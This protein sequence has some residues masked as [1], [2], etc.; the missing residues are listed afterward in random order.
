MNYLM[1][2]YY[3][4]TGYAGICYPMSALK[5]SLIFYEFFDRSI[6]STANIIHEFGHAY[7]YNIMDN[8]GMDG[9]TVAKNKTPYTEVSSKFLEYAF[10]NYLK[11]NRIYSDD[12]KM[13]LIKYY[14]IML[15]YIYNIHLICETES[16]T[17]NKYGYVEINDTAISQYANKIKEHL[18]YYTLA[19]D[20]GE[21]VNFR[22]SFI[23]GLGSLFSI[24]LYYNYKEDPNNFRKEFR[25]ALINY[26]YNGIEVFKN[27]G[28]NEEILI[29]GYTLKKKITNI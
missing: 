20:L 24:Y 21:E 12:T 17:F 13:C 28:I 1:L 18:N 14:K 15:K 27:I 25:N 4:S 5:S 11:E 22:N 6:H 2:T 10:L 7:E 16:L 19:S 8:I 3:N 26:Q 23:Y 9:W 29:K